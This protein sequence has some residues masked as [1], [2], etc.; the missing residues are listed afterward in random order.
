MSGVFD[1]RNNRLT[2][3]CHERLQQS[4]KNFAVHAK[5][6]Y[7]AVVLTCSNN[8]ITF[9]N[10]KINIGLDILRRRPDGYHDISTVMMPVPW[11]DVLEVVPASGNCD[12]LAVTGRK[13]DCP[14]EKNLVM[15]AV[16][17]LR[18]CADFPPVELHLHKVIPDGAGLGGGSAD[19]SF[20]LKAV[21]DLFGLGM[22]L[23]TLASVAATLGADCPFFIYN[24]PMLCEG[25]GTEMR[26]VDVPLPG[27]LML[28]IVKPDVSVPT[29]AAYAS[30]TPRVPTRSL[31]SL[32]CDEPFGRWQGLVKN[33]FERSV[34]PAFPEVA[35]VKELLMNEGAIYAS[36]SGSG[37]AVYAFFNHSDTLSD[38]FRTLFPDYS[39]FVADVS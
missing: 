9:P 4:L 35:R 19:A 10:A 34:F 23:E 31:E 21:N 13:V 26:P 29:A 18:D 1:G 2:D 24:T 6:R 33:D 27:R 12:T 15:R 5:C 30:V 38:H 37:S 14:P 17:A 22:A 8:M 39:V 16:K 25:T 7:F 3:S 32:L 36:M 28:V 20:A 11:C